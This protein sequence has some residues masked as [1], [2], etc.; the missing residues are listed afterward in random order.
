MFS[1]CTSAVPGQAQIR[2]RGKEGGHQVEC[3]SGPHYLLWNKSCHANP[4]W[5]GGTRRRCGR[6]WI[7]PR[8]M[9]A[10]NVTAPLP[11]CHGYEDGN[12]GDPKAESHAHSSTFLQRHCLCCQGKSMGIERKA[13]VFDLA[14]A[15]R[16]IPSSR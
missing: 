13:A 9:V 6:I 5:A 12:D 2:L 1:A 15:S 16:P 3:C 11:Q 4:V 8:I 10:W 7:L 14:N